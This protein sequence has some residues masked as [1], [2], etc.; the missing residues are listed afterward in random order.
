MR[1]IN[2]SYILLALLLAPCVMAGDLSTDVRNGAS[3]IHLN[4]ANYVEL[5]FATQVHDIPLKGVAENENDS[6]VNTSLVLSLNM[7]LQY[8]DWF[9]E[10]T[11]HSLEPF[12]FG[13]HIAD[14]NGWS[15]D[16]VA[17]GQNPEI[18]DDLKGIKK[19]KGDFMGGLRATGYYENYIVQ[20][21]ALTDIDQVHYGQVYSAKI[22]RHWQQKNWHFHTIL[23]SS[24]RSQ[25]VVD[26][27]YSV[28][29]EE[30]TESIPEFHAQAGF[31]NF[32]EAG[33]TYPISQKWV[34]RS[35]I[36][37]VQFDSRWADS[38]LMPTY[39][40]SVIFTSISYVF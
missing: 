21:H 6:D 38:P 35:F 19:R 1:K 5:E 17:L 9:V 26:Y 14:G 37:H 27:Y 33:A 4:E 28:Q 40:G 16:T 29:P 7:H 10:G 23:G 32:I 11:S 31:I 36:R 39:H 25:K 15:L 24:Y 18:G 34:F 22:A 13:Y 3:D 12:T 20:L 2:I 30:V 8:K